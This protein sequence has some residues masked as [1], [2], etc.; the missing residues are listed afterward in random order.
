MDEGT[1]Q[2]IATLELT[3]NVLVLARLIGLRH[4]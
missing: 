3:C 4:T 2:Q 1:M